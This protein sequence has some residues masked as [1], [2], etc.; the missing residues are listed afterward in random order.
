MIEKQETR[1]MH[2]A[3]SR[4]IF[5]AS[6]LVSAYL[7]PISYA[8]AQ[9]GIAFVNGEPITSRQVEQRMKVS[10]SLF[11]KPLSREA[12]IQEMIDDRVKITEGKRLGMRVT[13]AALEELMQRF[14]SSNRQ[15]P[16]QFEQNLIR[17]GIDPDAVRDKLTGEVIWT[18]LLRIRS[19]SNNISNAELNAELDRRVAKGESK[20]TD[21]VVRQVVFVVPSGVNPG[22]RE[23]EANA[24]RGRFTDCE[25]GVEYMRTL[26]DVAIKE[27]IGRTSSDLSKGTADLLAKTPIGRL[28][29]PFR[30]EQGIE[31]LAVCE[32]NDRE[33][34][35]ILRN[36]I[37]QE[38]LAKSTT[39]S[40]T[41]FLNELKSKVQISR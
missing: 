5:G 24:A 35:L 14:A 19:R 18:E 40:S 8:S 32:K 36:K 30:S 15:S 29:A 33:D 4:I 9:A 17:A 38:M 34:K 37:E 28:T 12:A 27:R 6:L 20:V 10:G 7:V 11:R 2:N 25:T 26:R 41:Q 13:P 21:Y 3:L 22:Q 39:T 23:R 16:A 1:S 31:M